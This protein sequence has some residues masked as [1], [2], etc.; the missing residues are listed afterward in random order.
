MSRMCPENYASVERP[1]E[2]VGAQVDHRVLS[3][4]ADGCPNGQDP[5]WKRI[6]SRTLSRRKVSTVT[7]ILGAIS[8][9]VLGVV[10]A[11]VV[12]DP[13]Q[14]F[15]ARVIGGIVPQR[16][17][18]LRG[19]WSSTY[20]F[21]SGSK[22][23]TTR[24]IMAMHQVGPFVVGKCLNSTGRHRHQIVGRIRDGVFTG[25]WHNVA[26]GA[27]HHGTLQLMIRPM[28]DYMEGKW[29]GFDSNGD[30]QHG[31]WHWHLL[32][33]ELKTSADVDWQAMAD[34]IEGPLISSSALRPTSGDRLSEAQSAPGSVP[35]TGV[36]ARQT[37]TER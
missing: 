36:Y 32:S 11:A 14:A 31:S 17:P 3:V 8:L 28:G 10:V 2:A 21:V 16:G 18:K 25:R 37:E 19:I 26:D 13:V 5:A 33:R 15:V 9:S 35:A 7:A 27:Q 4:V 12:N 34:Q 20:Q 6:D 30:V 24:Q 23:L 29:I 22:R 1:G